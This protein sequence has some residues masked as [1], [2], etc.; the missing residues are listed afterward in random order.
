M[1][2]TRASLVLGLGER[3]THIS[4]DVLPV[5][6]NANGY[7]INTIQD[8]GYDPGQLPFV[9]LNIPG[10]S[11]FLP[12]LPVGDPLPVPITVSFRLQNL[13]VVNEHIYYKGYLRATW[14]D[15]RLRYDNRVP[16]NGR[17]S[18]VKFGSP[19]EVWTPDMYFDKAS[20]S[21]KIWAD[22]GREESISVDPT[23]VVTWDR[24][25]RFDCECQMDFAKLPY[26]VQ[27][28]TFS[29][30]IYSFDDSQATLQWV[31]EDG[32]LAMPGWRT[33]ITLPEWTAVGVRPYIE[34]VP[35]YGSNWTYARATMVV[36]RNSGYYEQYVITGTILFV[37]LAWCSFFIAR[38]AAPARV[39]MGI[40][41]Y[42]VINNQM[43]SQL[44]LLPIG[45]SGVWI[46]NFMTVSRMFVFY[47]IIEY[48]LC[49]F[50]MRIEARVEKA[51]VAA[52]KRREDGPSSTRTSTQ[53]PEVAA[54]TA[55]KETQA[56]SMAVGGVSVEVAPGEVSLRDEVAQAAS[57]VTRWI[58]WLV[59]P[60]GVL[61]VRDQHVEV[62]TRWG[63][64]LA[65]GLSLT[66]FYA[67]T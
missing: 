52:L 36:S 25:A 49:N 29:I 12:W 15:R 21:W 27:E 1:S 19:E 64:P 16:Q 58:P 7:V 4:T 23:G 67:S 22:D 60:E 65:Y 20:Q 61:R 42:L 30:G 11:T 28:C 26:D 66:V 31:S 33:S 50:L 9:G 59:T 55:S 62:F 56:A 18:S 2:S 47:A 6:T 53:A 35:R 14:E 17:P 10:Q 51:R 8:D 32:D 63:F 38:A 54:S 13:K 48:A 44:G 5:V 41:L 34:V 24:K 57:S 45:S 40:I 3:V 39:A 37:M 46:L 43:N